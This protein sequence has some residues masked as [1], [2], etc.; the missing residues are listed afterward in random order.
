MGAPTQANVILLNSTSPA[1][2]TGQR[3][4]KPQEG[5]TSATTVLINNVPTPVLEAPVSL[6]VPNLG[7]VDA[8]STT[9]ETI[10]EAA[11]GKLVSL[12]AAGATAVTLNSSATNS[13]FMCFVSSRGAGGA[14]LTPSSGT[15]DGASSLALPQL[16]GV[17]LFFD[18]TNWGTERGLAQAGAPTS[19]EYVLGAVDA[20]LTNAAVNN[21]AYRGVD[22]T[23]ASPTAFDDEFNAGSL[24][25]IWSW[26]NQSPGTITFA[27][28]HIIMTTSS[29]GGLYNLHLIVESVPGSTPYT[30]TAKLW[31]EPESIVDVGGICL[32]DGTKIGAIEYVTAISPPANSFAGQIRQSNYATVTTAPT[33]NLNTTNYAPSA[34]V[35]FQITN[36]GT[37]VTYRYSY[38]GLPGTF[39]QIWQETTGAFLGTITK[40]GLFFYGYNGIPLF[41]CEWFRRTA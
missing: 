9:T 18:G 14:T 1:A 17:V 10:S 15:I 37:H 22:V 13:D 39:R 36:D 35:Y 16:N 31:M 40:I 6:Y 26:V 7:L 21:T 38:S 29:S 27:N 23:P 33:I 2:P 5:S 32:Y 3:N 28:S 12:N 24:G 11:N 30:F 8:R 20:S 41:A 34:P 25:G 19:S 4:A